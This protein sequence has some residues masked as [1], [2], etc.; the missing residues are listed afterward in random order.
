MIFRIYCD[1]HI[2]SIFLHQ[3]MFDLRFA[4]I[5]IEWSTP[6]ITKSALGTKLAS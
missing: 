1:Y 3:E 2:M 5:E 4:E 6:V